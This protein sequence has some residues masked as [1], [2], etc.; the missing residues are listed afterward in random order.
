[1]GLLYGSHGRERVLC[2][3]MVSMRANII[4]RTPSTSASPRARVRRGAVRLDDYS[5]P[6]LPG[7]SACNKCDG[8]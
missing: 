3:D 2:R 5:A 7:L 6:G 8:V 1:M 4:M